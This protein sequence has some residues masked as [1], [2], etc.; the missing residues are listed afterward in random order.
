L[1]F[2][3]KA[4]EEEAKRREEERTRRAETFHQ[5]VIFVVG[6]LGSLVFAGLV[7]VIENPSFI[8]SPESFETSFLW[9]V[10]A[11]Q[12]Y[13]VFIVGLLSA[14]S[15]LCIITCFISMM[16]QFTRYRHRKGR[17]FMRMVSYGAVG[18][19]LTSFVFALY[20][21]TAAIDVTVANWATGIST[22]FLIALAA[23]YGLSL[24]RK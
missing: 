22:L 14:I 4:E 20:V 5:N 16:A 2:Y 8:L 11:R 18:V 6:F 7:L 21:I 3:T 10:S 12:G 19:C 23:L 1:P 9:S 15:A 13:F 24:F 17:D